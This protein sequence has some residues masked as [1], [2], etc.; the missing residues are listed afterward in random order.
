MINFKNLF[1]IILIIILISGCEKEKDK[2]VTNYTLE[3]IAFDKEK[4]VFNAYNKSVYIK[5]K[6]MGE[7]PIKWKIE[8]YDSFVFCNRDSGNVYPQE[9]DSILTYVNFEEILV[10]TLNTKVTINVNDKNVDIP[11]EIYNYTTNKTVLTFDIIDA[12]YDNVHDKIICISNTPY[13]SLRLI[14]PEN[15]SNDSILLNY[16][17]TCISI[18]PDSKKAVIGHEGHVTYFDLESKTIIRTIDIAWNISDIVINNNAWVYAFSD[19]EWGAYRINLSNGITYSNDEHGLIYKGT[20]VKLH[21]SGEY[22]YAANNGLDPDDL[23]KYL[24]DQ[25][26]ITYMYDS[27]YHGEYRIDG[28]LW[29]TENGDRIISKTGY[30]FTTSE[31]EDQDILYSGSLEQTTRIH[32]LCHSN[33]AN[34]ICAITMLVDD[35][36]DWKIEDEVTRLD[37]YNGTGLNHLESIELDWFWKPDINGGFLKYRPLGRFVFINSAGTSIYV[38]SRAVYDSGILHEWGIEKIN[39][40]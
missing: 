8:R 1:C 22:I 25:D 32:S 19:D 14:N 31:L 6:N 20:R 35:W 5:F 4:L 38:I 10:D 11:I 21:P 37:V 36:Y 15:F 26:T 23:E 16:P 12:E 7:V 30:V 2:I 28:D 34:R 24:V 27:R 17:P 13:S 33:I 40:E 18:S 39:L 3:S 29:L 9:Y